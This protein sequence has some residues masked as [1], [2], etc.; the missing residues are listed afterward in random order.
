MIYQREKLLLLH[1]H[2]ARRHMVA[3]ESLTKLSPGE[4]LSVLLTVSLPPV[5][6]CTSKLSC[7][8]EDPLLI[9]APRNV[10]LSLH[11]TEPVIRPK[12]IGENG[13]K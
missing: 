11:R 6:S 3:S 13:R 9:I 5:Q 8:I 4:A 10:K 12:R 7:C 1:L 2:Y